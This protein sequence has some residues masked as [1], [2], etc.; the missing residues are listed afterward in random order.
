MEL[1]RSFIRLENERDNRSLPLLW[2]GIARYVARHP[3]YRYLYGAVSISNE[4]RPFSRQLMTWFLRFNHAADPSFAQVTPVNPPLFNSNDA[5]VARE[6]C[7]S[8]RTLDD[9]SDF[10]S[11]IEPDSKGV[12]VLLRHYL[13]L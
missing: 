4:Y 8:A 10:V 13:R 9:L 6:Y 1:G 5:R 11:E 2:A 3:Q 12:P 7:R